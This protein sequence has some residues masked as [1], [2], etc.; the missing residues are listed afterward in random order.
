MGEMDA[1]DGCTRRRDPVKGENGFVKIGYKFFNNIKW[2][3]R[4]NPES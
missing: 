3:T 2:I 1:D 4:K